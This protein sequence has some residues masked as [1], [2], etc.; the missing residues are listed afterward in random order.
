MYHGEDV[1]LSH[2]GDF[3]RECISRT[4]NTAGPHLFYFRKKKKYTS[5]SVQQCNTN[6][7]CV[8]WCFSVWA[9]SLCFKTFAR[10]SIVCATIASAREKK[11]RGRCISFFICFCCIIITIARA[12]RRPSQMQLVSVE[13]DVLCQ[14][15]SGCGQVAI[16]SHGEPAWPPVWGIL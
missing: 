9:D 10:K 4:A 11:D 6:V 2:V 15:V 8:K 16:T 12:S 5:S 14:I 1:C 7:K 3:R 13:R